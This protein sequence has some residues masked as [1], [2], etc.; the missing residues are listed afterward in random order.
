MSYD[1]TV[2]RC[3]SLSRQFAMPE[4]ITRKEEDADGLPLFSYLSEWW[5]WWN[6]TM[7]H[8]AAMLVDSIAKSEKT[9]EKL[10]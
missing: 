4:E 7:A 3:V 1:M 2:K 5:L 10:V 9:A 6:H 8:H